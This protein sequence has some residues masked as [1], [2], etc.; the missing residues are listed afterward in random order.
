MY[1]IVTQASFQFPVGSFTK[2]N[3]SVSLIG[4]CL[5]LKSFS[6]INNYY[7][8][9]VCFAISATIVLLNFVY[10]RLIVSVGLSF[11]GGK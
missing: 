2:K 3:Q 11:E 6:R 1:W 9:L 8:W 7:A 10:S 5:S 4:Y